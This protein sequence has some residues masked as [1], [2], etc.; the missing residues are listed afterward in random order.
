MSETVVVPE[1]IQGLVLVQYVDQSLTECTVPVGT[2]NKLWF[3]GPKDIRA[4]RGFDAISLQSERWE[5]NI[6][7]NYEAEIM[8]WWRGGGRD[9]FGLK[10]TG[11]WK[12]MYR[13]RSL[14]V[15]Y[16]NAHATGRFEIQRKM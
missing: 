3:N 11:N 10:Y 9:W 15:P 16:C 2:V 13:S 8:I 1:S 12:G 6:K 14:D 7:E 5:Y 4:L